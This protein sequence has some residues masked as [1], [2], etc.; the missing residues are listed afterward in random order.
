MTFVLGYFILRT[1]NQS[2]T[3]QELMSQTDKSKLLKKHFQLDQKL[4]RAKTFLE[5]KLFRTKII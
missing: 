1:F 2:D 5:Q 3:S 4:L